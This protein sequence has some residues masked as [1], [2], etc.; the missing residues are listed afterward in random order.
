MSSERV[1]TELE[2]EMAIYDADEAKIQERLRREVQETWERNEANN[3]KRD[4]ELFARICR[5]TGAKEDIKR[6][7]EEPMPAVSD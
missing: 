7:L 2:R 1:P 5:S 6:W 3:R 4:D